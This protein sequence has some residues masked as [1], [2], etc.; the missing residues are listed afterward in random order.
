MLVK[1]KSFDKAIDKFKAYAKKKDIC[2]KEVQFGI[3]IANSILLK[4]K[5]KKI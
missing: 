1:G 2:L 4:R 5:L 3:R